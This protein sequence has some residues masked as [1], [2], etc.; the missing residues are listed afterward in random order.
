M[1]R[2]ALLA[3]G[4]AALLGLFLLVVFVQRFRLEAMG[5]EPVELFALARNVPAGQRLAEQNLVA[6]TLPR[7][8][9]E[10]RHVLRADLERVIG[11][12]ASIELEAGQTL[13]WTDL[14]TADRGRAT[15]ASRIP[16][17]MRAMTLPRTESDAFAGLLQ[18]GDR[19][20]VLLTRGRPGEPTHIVTVTLLQNLLV[21]AVGQS[22]GSFEEVEL[23]DRRSAVS[24]LLTI[25]QATLLAQARRSGTLRLLLRNSDDVEIHDGLPETDDADVLEEQKRARRQRTGR[26][27]R[28]N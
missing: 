23:A 13:L 28:V 9:V 3:A 12:P 20:D 1:N 25:Q 14:A 5:G 16:N 24:L 4:V 26:L 8:F 11:V 17:G 10:S 19:V 22:V 2:N 27:E 21:L 7:N 18:P 6:R 15:L